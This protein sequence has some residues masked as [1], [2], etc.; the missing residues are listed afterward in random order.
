MPVPE[1]G[2]AVKLTLSNSQ[3]EPSSLTNPED[4]EIETPVSTGGAVSV[5]VTL[6]GE[7]A[8]DPTE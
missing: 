2:K 6:A 1:D 5:T 4:S 3:M 8:Q 7:P